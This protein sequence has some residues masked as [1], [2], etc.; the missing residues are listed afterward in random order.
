[1]TDAT[2]FTWA[3][4]MSCLVC[5]LLGMIFMGSLVQSGWITMD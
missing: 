4:I 2:R 1:M 3:T 5:F